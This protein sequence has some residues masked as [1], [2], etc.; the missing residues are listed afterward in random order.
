MGRNDRKSRET[1][2]WEYP[3][4]YRPTGAS[5]AMN[6]YVHMRLLNLFTHKNGN[7]GAISVTEK[8][9][10]HMSDTFCVNTYSGQSASCY[11]GVRT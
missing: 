7:L 10:R 3:A 4:W 11:L 6:R 5:T 1:F 8:V 9:E 2:K